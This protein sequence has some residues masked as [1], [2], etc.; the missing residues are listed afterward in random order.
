MAITYTEESIN[1]VI[2]TIS[3][4]SEER[5]IKDFQVNKPFFATLMNNSGHQ[6]P[7]GLIIDTSD[8]GFL[9]IQMNPFNVNSYYDYEFRYFGKL[10]GYQYKKGLINNVLLLQF[11]KN[12]YYKIYLNKR[13]FNKVPNNKENINYFIQS[14]EQRTTNNFS[15]QD[16]FNERKYRLIRGFI[17]WFIAFILFVMTM[18]IIAYNAEDLI[19]GSRNR[20]VLIIL[21]LFVIYSL[22]FNFVEK[23]FFA[24]NYRF[25]HEFIKIISDDSEFDNPQNTLRRLLKMRNHPTNTHSKNEYYYALATCYEKLN[26]TNQALE[27]YQTIDTS[28]DDEYAQ[29][30]NDKIAK[31][32][33]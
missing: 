9:I 21:V 23:R 6:Q 28:E 30:I 8:K 17:F 4:S 33:R 2:K 32:K 18:T 20:F 14:L 3:L 11:N 25:E 15:K 13:H 19:L 1:N 24:R 12:K 16:I 27:A 10:K 26:Q 5:N 29:I 31:L 22:I 7:V